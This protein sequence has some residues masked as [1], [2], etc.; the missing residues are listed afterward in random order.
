MQALGRICL[1]MLRRP[2]WPKVDIKGLVRPIND[3]LNFYVSVMSAVYVTA[4]R[5]DQWKERLPGEDLEGRDP[6]W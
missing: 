6:D 2:E 3:G 1:P 4:L 5:L